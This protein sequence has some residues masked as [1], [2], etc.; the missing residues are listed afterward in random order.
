M[1]TIDAINIPGSDIYVNSIVVAN[2]LRHMS[3]LTPKERDK[4]F[5]H[6]ANNQTNRH[7]I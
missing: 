4:S 3:L 7:H 5:R 2:Y 6:T 1:D